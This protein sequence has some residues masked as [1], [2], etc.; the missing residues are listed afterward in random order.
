MIKDKNDNAIV[1]MRNI[2]TWLSFPLISD[3]MI[4][5]PWSVCAKLPS[6]RP[7]CKQL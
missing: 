7:F 3:N 4:R 2:M 6:I 5:L 1:T